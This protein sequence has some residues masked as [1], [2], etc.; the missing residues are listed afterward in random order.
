MEMMNNTKILKEV[1]EQALKSLRPES[2]DYFKELLTEIYVSYELP[3]NK[4]ISPLV[5][6][7]NMDIQE[8]RKHNI[9]AAY[10]AFMRSF[11]MFLVLEK[12]LGDINKMY[13]TQ[14]FNHILLFINDII[15]S[16]NKN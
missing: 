10:V 12:K 6:I 14:Q 7:W 2:L 1:I 11:N 13:Y 4:E 8:E 5:I 9:K 15:V 16:L 3:L